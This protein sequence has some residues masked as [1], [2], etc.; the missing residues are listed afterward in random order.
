LG[1]QGIC[2]VFGAK[3]FNM[4]QVTHGVSIATSITNPKEPLFYGVPKQFATG[5][6][7][8]WSVEPASIPD[9]LV[10]SALAEDKTVMAVSHK[11]FDVKG[12]QFH[13][14]SI[15]TE[16]GEKIMKNWLTN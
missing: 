1:Y 4:P 15:L 9:S 10:I 8:S 16:H 11:N 13:P 3:L 7:H 6:Y 12:L 14:E 2:E 5:R